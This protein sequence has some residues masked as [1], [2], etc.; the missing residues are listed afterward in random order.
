MV[1]EEDLEDGEIESDGET[2]DCVVVE[3]KPPP[4]IPKAPEK[5]SPPSKKKSPS[6]SHS[7]SS[8][9]SGS[10]SRKEKG[11][12]DEDD[13]MSKIENALAEN[14]KKS[15]IEPPMPSVK[16]HVE[17]EQEERKS[18]KNRNRKSKKR[19][20]KDQKRDSG[21][22]RVG[23]ADCL[24]DFVHLREKSL[25][26]KRMKV[27]ENDGFYMV[28]GSPAHSGSE[29]EGDTSY[30]S[31]D[32]DEY[33]R[34]TYEER[35]ARRREKYGRGRDRSRDR[36]RDDKNRDRNRDRKEK[37]NRDAENEVCLRFSEFGHCPDVS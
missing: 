32:S 1:E 33:N 16:K 31:Y 37:K 24:L 11:N 30:S 4:E 7:K 27:S 34:M 26:P 12:H 28:G 29:S 10:S 5:S 17:P 36:D 13:F 35:R 22:S 25:Q 6:D 20:R 3:V 19:E 8:K 9:S 18:R 14:L 23:F 15:G 21:S 2:E